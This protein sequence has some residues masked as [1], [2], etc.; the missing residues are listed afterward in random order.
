M[1]LPAQRLNDGGLR[2][3]T[4][5]IDVDR[6]D[7]GVAVVAQVVTSRL[8]VVGGAAEGDEHRVCVGCLVLLDQSVVPAGQFA[9]RGAGLLDHRQD[10][11]VEVVPACHDAVHVVFLVLDGPEQ[12]RVLHVHHLRHPAAART[13]QL[14]LGGGRAVDQILGGAEVFTQELR[15]RGEVHAF[16]VGCE[17]AVL[18]VHARIER[19]FV[20]PPQDDGLVG[21]LLGVL[22][23]HHRPARVQGRVEIVMTAVHVERLF[24]QGAGA[25]LEHHGRKLARRVVVLLHR[26]DDAL[27]RG[28]IAGAPA[29]DRERRGSALGGVLALG[30]DGDLLL[31]PDV[32]FALGEG[33]LV[34]F[35]TF[36][37][38]RDRVED[39]ALGH[40]GL[41]VLGDELVAV[42]GHPQPRVFRFDSRRRRLRRGRR[43]G[44]GLRRDDRL[45]GGG[46]THG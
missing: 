42:A 1:L 36:G 24:G 23:H 37:R 9:E 17:H 20:D 32:Q 16:T 25:D 27:A 39:A 45:S 19:E 22:G 14:P 46:I 31:T 34:D 12:H 40:P 35:A 41:D 13:E 26:V 43:S 29:R 33:R 7:P 30:F 5:D 15:L 10:V 8:D 44:N 4:D 28:E 11:L 18:D 6:P 3:G 2:E 38:W 21:G